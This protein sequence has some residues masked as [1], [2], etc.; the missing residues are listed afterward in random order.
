M[1]AKQNFMLIAQCLWQDSLNRRTDY[2]MQC[3]MLSLK[4]AKGPHLLS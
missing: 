2:T 4:A 3:H 1:L